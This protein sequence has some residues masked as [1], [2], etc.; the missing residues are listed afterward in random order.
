MKRAQRK[1]AQT[2]GPHSSRRS[3]AALAVGL[4]FC[5][6]ATACGGGASTGNGGSGGPDLHGQTIEVMAT[7]TGDEQKQFQHVLDLFQRKTGATVKYTG[8]GDELPTVLQTRVQG[9]TPPNVAIVAQ[10][11]LIDQLAKT[12]A[13]TPLRPDVANDVRQHSGDAWAKFGSANGTPYGVYFKAGNKS[14]VWYNDKSFAQTGATPPKTWA[15]FLT[16][17]KQ[18]ADAGVTP[19]SIGAADGWVLTDWFEN[20][21]LQTAGSD[22]YDKLTR[23]EIPWTDPSVR[24]ALEILG[25]L[26]SQPGLIAGG[27]GGALQTDFSNSVVNVFGPQPKAAMLYEQDAVGTVIKQNTKAQVGVDAKAFPF[28]A[29]AGNGAAVVAG[30]DAGVALKNDPAT[31]EFLKFLASPEAG[32]TWA[33][34]GGFISPNRDVPLDTYPDEPTRQ[35]AKQL[36]DAGDNVRYD[37]SD[38]APSSFGSTKGAGEWKDLQDFF[39]NPTDIDGAMQRLEA[40]AAKAYGK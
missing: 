37:M 39:A 19:Q 6:G 15:D 7:W 35:L 10:P 16:L 34:L 3:W 17:S 24:H 38:Q 12:H 18:L 27:T 28:P 21:Y 25:Q 9:G 36:I 23:H 30:G 14:T 4:T 22:M 29:V 33:K 1:Q 13:L 26:F 8:A 40:D 11:G 2:K 20:V 5:A 31:M 32:E